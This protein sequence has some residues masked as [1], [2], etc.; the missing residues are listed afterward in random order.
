MNQ[1]LG[2]CLK[3]KCS[4][5]HL[6]F[7]EEVM[8]KE[9]PEKNSQE[10]SAKPTDTLYFCCNGCQGVYHLL[11]NDG[12]DSFYDKLGNNTL[13]PADTINRDTEKFDLETFEKRYVKTTEA[14]YK[15]VYLIIE[16]IHCAACVWLNEKVLY[17]KE[18]IIE[19]SINFSTNKAKI[20]WDDDDIQ[21]SE[22]IQTIR[23]IGYNAY[24]YDKTIGEEKITK[25]KREFFIKVMVAVFATMNMMM[26]GVAKY[27]GFFTGISETQKDLIHT[28]EL[29][30]T[31][32]V[33]FYSGMVFF[34]GAYYGLKN[35][36]LNM[37][38]LVASGASF[39]FIYS[40]YTYFSGV[41][42]TYF[43]SVTMIITFVLVGK[44]LEV[45]GKKGAVDTLDT[46]KS[47]LPTEALIIEDNIKKVVTPDEIQVG[48]IIEVKAGEKIVVDGTIISGSSN[49]DESSLS[50]E[51]I[52]IH[53]KVD[54]KIY[55]G[56]LNLDGVIRYKAIND[57]EHSSLNSI[58]TLLED[59]LSS[60]PQ[61]EEKA[62]EISKYF[63]IA[64]LSISAFAFVLWYFFIDATPW[65]LT[66]ESSNFERAFIVAISV[67]V[68]ACPCALALATP[69]ASLIGISSLA[70]KGLI[71][72]E[73]KS[74]ETIAKVNTLVLDKTGTITK[75]KLEVIEAKC[76]ELSLEEVNI[77]YSLVSASNHPVSISVKN[78]LKKIYEDVKE[79]E[80]GN[81]EQIQAKGL[82]ADFEGKSLLGGNLSLFESKSIDIKYEINNTQFI[83]T[84]DG[85]L[86]ALFELKDE[87]K[88]DVKDVI[89]SIK[90]LGVEVVMLT[91]D[92]EKVAK[93]VA[94]KVGIDRYIATVDPI[95]KAAFIKELKNQ[96]K[97][98]IMA[99]DGIN[100]A[101]ALSNSDISIAMGSGAD[102]A[103]E[104]SDVVVLNN[105][106]TALKDT[107]IISHNTYKTI[108][109]NLALSLLYNVITVP[110][111]LAGFIIPLVAALSMSLSSLV[112]VG[113]SVR[114]KI[115]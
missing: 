56:T 46:I 70:N 27:S 6:E 100:D 67:I 80:L 113:N 66:H 64:I 13:T 5:C 51:S 20:I 109:Q 90:A 48:N 8:I 105:S 26:V 79:L 34:K 63:S 78:Y 75:G 37:D 29:I 32:P 69:I 85:E 114:T 22:I 17:K 92:N 77:L 11:K 49:F 53:K 52:P 40:L 60:K 68:I 38:F 1:R 111:A 19:A 42:E 93:D 47:T 25:A 28:A 43:D 108:K 88:E 74:L 72:K 115:K 3:T 12:L 54:D 107:L 96:G 84:I 9:A 86:K 91:G 71:F 110:L 83:F 39:T 82:K 98:V 95:Q 41:G 59:S 76:K 30:F 81:I 102:V 50:G 24:P 57:F 14:G 55:S 4:H 58:V 101:L 31:I 18:G 73:A 87:I 45:I 33:L 35:K 106:F 89:K 112:V 97:I 2:Q 10:S 15:Q 103:I 44:Y 104:V 36:I 16:G 61:I 7:D 62:N 23:N 99:G 65:I 94:S 21:L